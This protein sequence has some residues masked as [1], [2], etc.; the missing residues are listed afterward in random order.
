MGPKKRE[1]IQ[2]LVGTTFMWGYF[3]LSFTRPQDWMS[4]LSRVPMAK[5][6]SVLAV[7]AILLSFQQFRWPLPR[8]AFWLLLLMGQFFATVPMSPVWPGGAFQKTLDFGKVVVLF[9]IIV[10]FATTMKRLQGLILI[11]CSSAAVFSALSVWN[12]RLHMGRLG[13]I[14]R[15][16]SANPNDLALGLVTILPLSLALMFLNRSLLG[17]TIWGLAIL[18]MMYAVFLTGSRG[19]FISLIVAGAVCLWEFAVRGRGHGA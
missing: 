12:A 11:Q 17:K 18:L 15:A 7:L 10:S 8:N 5:I 1:S 3:V 6:A 14:T 9:V 4:D 2:G 13:A 19:G 16:Y